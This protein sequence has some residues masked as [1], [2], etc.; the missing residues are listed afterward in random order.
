MKVSE[1]RLE[2]ILNRLTQAQ[3]IATVSREEWRSIALELR[4]LRLRTSAQSRSASASQ[5][6]AS[7]S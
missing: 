4:Q 1:Q 2:D 6:A 5:G 7:S 3:D